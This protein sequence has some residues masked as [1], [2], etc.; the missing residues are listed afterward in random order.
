MQLEIHSDVACPWCWIGKKRM[1]KAVA[2]GLPA[3]EIRWRAFLL[4]P[5][6]PAEGVDTMAFFAK[7]FG[8]EAK[9]KQMFDHVAAIGK[10]E[11]LDF[12]F[13]KMTRASNTKLAHRLVALARARGQ[14]NPA[15][16]VFFKGQFELGSDMG[17]LDVLLELLDGAG[18]VTEG[19]REAI[20]QGEGIAE[21]DADFLLARRRGV[22]GVPFFVAGNKVAMSGA[23]PPAAFV[24][25]FQQAGA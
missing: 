6:L 4:Q 15:V 7:K 8:G 13:D 25:L 17:K 5:D 11:G 18:V 20:A 9:V 14:E 21:V 19:M 12:R 22:T 16:D 2:G 3:P 10:T 23:Q 1:E 24:Q